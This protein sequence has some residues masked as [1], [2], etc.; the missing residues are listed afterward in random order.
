MR[1]R[2]AQWLLRLAGRLLGLAGVL[3][4][5]GVLALALV[6][7]ALVVSA[8]WWRHWGRPQLVRRSPHPLPM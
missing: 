5:P 7:E 8:W 3:G 4:L 2:G 6:V 1:L